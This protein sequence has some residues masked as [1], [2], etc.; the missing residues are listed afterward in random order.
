MLCCPHSTG[1]VC[2]TPAVDRPGTCPS[3][4]EK[5]ERCT[6]LCSADSECGPGLKCC[7]MGCGFDCVPSLE[8]SEYPSNTGVKPGECP[9]KTIFCFKMSH[10]MCNEDKQCPNEEKCCYYQCGSSCL[11]KDS[12]GTNPCYG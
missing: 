8:D 10:Q 6:D 9:P 5:G 1:D 7:M 11:S 3:S 2:K 12:D 4:T